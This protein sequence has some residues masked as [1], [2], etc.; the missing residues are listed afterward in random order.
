MRRWL[1]AA[2]VCAAAAS[3]AAQTAPHPDDPPAILVSRPLLEAQH[4][5]VGDVVMLSAEPSGAHPRPFRIAGAYEPTPDP[6]RLGAVRHEVRLHL[7]DL[8]AMTADPSDPL[9][10]ESVDAINVAL[11]NPAD[12]A[13]FARTATARL[14]GLI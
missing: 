13:T 11:A 4:L 10:A 1:L 8:I 3:A 5:S 7:P 12:A 2:L 9:A 14:P 6:M